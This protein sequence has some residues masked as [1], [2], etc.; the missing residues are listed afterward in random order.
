MS[1]KKS[2]SVGN[3]P[4][5]LLLFCNLYGLQRTQRYKRRTKCC[6]QKDEV[7]ISSAPIAQYAFPCEVVEM[8]REFVLISNKTIILNKTIIYIYV[9][10]KLSYLFLVPWHLFLRGNKAANSNSSDHP[11]SNCCLISY[12]SS[13]VIEFNDFAS[14]NVFNNCLG[15]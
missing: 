8:C 5:I 15:T 1:E 11:L 12:S 6:S 4:C 14:K 3:A 9:Y 10:T 7:E 13:L 2:I